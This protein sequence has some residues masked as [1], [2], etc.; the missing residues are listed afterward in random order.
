MLHKL[1]YVRIALFAL[2]V[3]FGV[4]AIGGGVSLL[5]G[6]IRYPATWLQG[7][8]FSDYTIPAYVLAVVVG[9]SLF[10]AAATMFIHREWAVLI[11]VVAGL[12]LAGYMVVQ[13][14]TI[15]LVNATS[16]D[17]LFFVS[18]LVIFGLGTFLWMAEYGRQHVQSRHVRHA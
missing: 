15:G 9:G 14:A 12:F 8:P 3:F 17:V 10:V 11:S 18:G 16:N 4:T 6:L 2:E 5:I 7:T 13:A 1:W